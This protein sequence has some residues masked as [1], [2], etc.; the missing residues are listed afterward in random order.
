M[1]YETRKKA[2]IA[3][4]TLLA[5]TAGTAW[6]DSGYFAVAGAGTSSTNI[7]R[8]LFIP[9]L[10]DDDRS[11]EIGIGYAFSPN[12]SVQAGYHD[13]GEYHGE[14]P[15]LIEVCG[16]DPILV[17]AELAGWSLRV[18][19]AY[20]FA[21]RFAVFAS[22]GVLVWDADV[23]FTLPEGIGVF[24]GFSNESD[25]LMYEAGLRWRLSARWNIQASYEKVNLDV[26]S[27]K[28]GLLFRF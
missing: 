24:T 7:G 14:M 13:Y 3:G 11:F 2:V 23:D 19:G 6:A 8:A 16:P 9:G 10:S 1:S 20:P 5:F 4:S 15:C 22:A 21:E 25:D 12:L 17:Q 18:T 27:A 26:E 28:L